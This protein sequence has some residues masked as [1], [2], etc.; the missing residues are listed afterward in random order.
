MTCVANTLMFHKLNFYRRL[1][2]NK[3][4]T[5][6]FRWLFDQSFY[7]GI[8]ISACPSP[9]TISSG[10]ISNNS[11][12]PVYLTKVKYSCLLGFTLNGSTEIYCNENGQWNSSAPTCDGT[13][14][15]QSF[16]NQPSLV[17]ITRHFLFLHFITID[18]NA[19]CK[20]MFK[21]QMSVV[22]DI[23]DILHTPHILSAGHHWSGKSIHYYR[24][25]L[26]G[27]LSFLSPLY[28]SIDICIN[29][30][31]PIQNFISQNL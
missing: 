9:K 23:L 14:E 6:L 8:H 13:Y 1:S 5:T 18:V 22:I 7:R 4:T 20:T 25:L 26:V 28:I 27:S 16:H 24:Y 31:I 21:D 30:K 3:E 2:S 29:D 10:Q 19:F 12:N 11:D 15:D 17:V